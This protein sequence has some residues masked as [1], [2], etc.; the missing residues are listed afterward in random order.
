[1][2]L[3]NSEDSKNV[4]FSSHAE[5]ALGMETLVFETMVRERAT[6]LA[7][8]RGGRVTE[9]TSSDVQYASLDIRAGLSSLRDTAPF[10]PER[11]VIPQ[12]LVLV[13]ILGGLLIARALGDL[14]SEV[15]QQLDIGM[16]VVTAMMLF[17][18]IAR[19]VTGK[20]L[21]EAIF[22]LSSEEDSVEREERR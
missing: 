8:G 21:L 17:L 15:E 5:E 12:L 3:P 2:H 1:M 7:S 13:V 4:E 18:L 6:E 16:G 14:S 9:V 10:L 11:T 19:S 20:L 22:P